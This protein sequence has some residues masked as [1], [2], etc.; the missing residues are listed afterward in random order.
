[1]RPLAA[2]CTAALLVAGVATLGSSPVVRA[3][4]S[5]TVSITEFMASNT[6]GATCNQAGG[7]YDWVELRN[8]SGTPAEIG[9]MHMTDTAASPAKWTFPS[10]FTVPANG[11]SVLCLGVDGDPNSPAFS[12]KKDGEYLALTSS[13]NANVGPTFTFPAQYDDVSYGVGSNAVTGFLP[14]PTPGAANGPAQAQ[15]AHVAR[16]VLSPKGGFITGAVTVTATGPGT[17]HYTTNGTAPTESSTV[18]PAGGLSV[19]PGTIVRVAAFQTGFLPS[20]EASG[21]YL[22]M[23]GVL[24]QTTATPRG[25]RRPERSTGRSSSMAWT[26]R[27]WRRTTRRSSRR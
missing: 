6:T 9:G 15:L 4:D 19:Q 27:R 18:F 7:P 10:G 1:M 20:T 5:G 8:S 25:G 12:L 23:S 2:V 22:S 14:A 16:P 11:Y 21:T 24:G 26:S 17:K 3:A 13:L